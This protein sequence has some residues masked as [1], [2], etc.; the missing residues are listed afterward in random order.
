MR[1]SPVP[2]IA[3]IPGYR[4]LRHPAPIDLFLDGNEGPMASVPDAALEP[5][6]LRRYP[7][8]A[9]LEKE[10]ADR[11][12]AAPSEVVACAGAD[13]ALDR[14]CR[15]F[16]CAGR[17]LVL[18]TPTFEMLARY[19]RLTGATV[20]PVDWPTGAYPTDDVIAA[21]NDSTR[22]I[23]VV[24]PN[25][26]TGAVASSEDLVRVSAAAPGAVVVLDGAYAEFADDDLLAVAR[27]L[28]N[29]VVTRT[30]SKAWGLAG[31]RIGY[32][33]G[34]AELIDCLRR[35]G[36]PYAVAGPSIALARGRLSA[37]GPDQA[38]ID[39]VR[40]ERSSLARALGELGVDATPSQGNFV[41]ARTAR[42]RWLADGLAGLGIAARSWPD[43]PG[44]DDAV[45]LSC[46]G[47]EA[48]FRRL[49]KALRAVLDPRAVLFDM[50]GVLADVS[51][52]YRRAI[53]E[54]AASFG[55]V[56]T[57]AEVA[58]AKAEGD[59]NNDWRL[60]QRLVAAGGVQA[61]LS[62]VTARF[63]ALYQ[64]GL[65]RRETCLIPAARLRQLA[66]RLPIAVV[67]GRPRG[68]AERFL[69]DHDL[70]GLFSTVVSMEDAAA[71]PDP[72]PV[73]L[74][75][76]RLGVQQAWMIGDTP[77]DVTAARA[78]GVV[79]LGFGDASAGNVLLASGAAR[80]LSCIDE[81][82]EVLP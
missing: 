27:R 78:A 21:C 18:P 71:K 11:I 32:A 66:A 10:L 68:D 7:T 34:P 35:A 67:T 41:L 26:P 45:R 62:D 16:L 82:F 57:A 1:P 70:A 37:G 55:V 4:V 20:V 38:Y 64:G 50:D 47:D 29:V 28:P 49:T 72:A 73:R 33:I 36:Q 75:L 52:S 77:D 30:L 53:V 8:C 19:A 69:D 23:A 40:R 79:P 63:E 42:S 9:T 56:L 12:G 59:A 6:V 74:A 46:P 24:S 44:L 14:L 13:D 65:Y 58:Q 15:A 51:E 76:E 25:N 60:T 2:A 5:D 48:S 54:T 43:R 17:E 31:L 39:E 81:L 80:M 3:T 61:T 22:L